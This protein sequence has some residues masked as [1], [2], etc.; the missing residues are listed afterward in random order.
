MRLKQS[1][2][3]T[4]AKYEFLA[5]VKRKAFL[6]TAFGF[7]LFIIL[8][9]GIGFLF[10][11]KSVSKSVLAPVALVDQSNILKLDLQKVIA[12]DR[13]NVPL[14]VSNDQ[15]KSDEYQSLLSEKIKIEPFTDTNQ[16]LAALKQNLVSA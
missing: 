13:R 12:E 9:G 3:F 6:L 1:K 16:A 11:T 14:P 10:V 8:A 4:I 15:M 7:P 5:T 2:T